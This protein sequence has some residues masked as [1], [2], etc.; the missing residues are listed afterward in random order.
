MPNTQ[1]EYGIVVGVD[2]SPEA[3]AAI[4][5]ATREAIQRRQPL[6]LLHVVAPLVVAWPVIPVATAIAEWQVE[7]ANHVLTTAAQTVHAA[8]GNADPPELRTRVRH[9]AVAGTIVDWSR[10]ALMT[11]VGSRRI[12]VVRR[13]LEGSV[14]SHVLH[15]AS[16][17]VVIVHADEP[18]SLDPSSPVV[19]GI[20]GSPASE[21]ATAWAFDA[22][23]RRGVPLIAL[24]AWADTSL[25]TLFGI[26]CEQY[27]AEGHEVLA[28]RLA[29][30][31]E[32]YPDVIVQRRIAVDNP[33]GRLVDASEQAQLV[34]VG[35]HG[36]GGFAGT[37]LG[38]VGARVCAGAAVPTVVVRPRSPDTHLDR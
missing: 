8:A 27:E 38:S 33:A 22:A 25:Q 14:S 11:V 3:E 19:L 13:V 6:T 24:H 16:G 7:N 26:D 35:S 36:R 31:Q 17:P 20:D 37:V 2:G 32:R 10:G 9:A 15:H 23:S 12:G 1:S 28:E 34:V 18:H 21:A 29:G 30:W 4:R 5:W